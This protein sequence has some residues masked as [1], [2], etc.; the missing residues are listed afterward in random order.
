[1][2]GERGRVDDPGGQRAASDRRRAVHGVAPHRRAR[3]RA[4]PRRAPTGD[5]RAGRSPARRRRCRDGDV[6]DAALSV[7]PGAFTRTDELA[8]PPFAATVDA[9]RGERPRRPRAS[10]WGPLRAGGDVHPGRAPDVPPHSLKRELDFAIPVNPAAMPMAR[11]H[12]PRRGPL[13]GP[14]GEDAARHHGREPALHRGLGRQLGPGVRVA[15]VRHVPGGVSPSA[16][17]VSFTRHLTHRAV[18]GISMGGGGAG[19]FGMRH[20][21]QFDVIGAAGRQQRPHVARLVLRAVQVR[22]LLHRRE[23]QLHQVRAE[24]VPALGDVRPHGGL[25]SLVLPAG[26]GTGGSFAPRGLDADPRGLPIMGGDPNGQNADPAIPF[27]VVGPTGTSPFVAG[28]GV[29]DP[30]TGKPV[31]CGITIDPIAADARTT[32][33]RCRRPRRRPQTDQQAV[34][35]ACLASRCDPKNAWMAKTGFYDARVQP[36]RVAS[37]SSASATAATDGTD[38]RT[39]TRG[40]RRRPGNQTPSDLDARG[41]PQRQRHPRRGRAGHPPGRGALPGHRRGR[42][43]RRAGA[44]LRPGD[45]PGPEP[46]RLRL[47]AEPERDREQP[48]LR[49]RGAVPGRRARRR[50]E[51]A[52]AV[53]RRVRP[54]RG[55]R[56]VSRCRTGAQRLFSN[57]PHSILHG[58]VDRPGRPDGRRGA[59]APR[60]VGRRRRAGHGELR[61]GGQPPHRG[62]R[63]GEERRRDAGE[64]DRVLQQLREP[65]RRGPDAAE[66]VPRGERALERR[67]ERGAPPLRL[68]RRDAGD[69]RAGRRAARRAPGARSSIGS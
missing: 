3:R 68:R 38:A 60:R 46:G 22:R 64:V 1:M 31:N 11:A 55:R 58:Q 27:M 65:P 50:A 67:R 30:A 19:I 26:D 5:S 40:R 16:G 20:H 17:T 59:P 35:S 45:E 2:T 69:D 43:R 29:T 13:L 8:I 54:R 39:S 36:R 61:R 44:R 12:A 52:A 49:A 24:H 63:V 25:R 62:R 18:L 41:R 57:D 10:R 51:H 47:P 28:V 33:R 34:Q 6:A 42:P 15:L 32:A 9:A 21:D 66:L 53:E 56:Q 7:P 23:P 14:D 48:H 37:R 4:A